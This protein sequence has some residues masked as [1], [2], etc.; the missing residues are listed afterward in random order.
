MRGGD[1]MSDDALLEKWA[2]LEA[3]P[4][5]RRCPGCGGRLMHSYRHDAFFCP[6]CDVWT[7][8]VCKVP[9]CEYCGGRPERPS[10]ALKGPGRSKPL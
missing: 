3:Y 1:A 6:A 10:L 7:E 9:G 4:I 2:A 5:E 8:G